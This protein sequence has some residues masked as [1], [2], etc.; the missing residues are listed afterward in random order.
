MTE[1]GSSA[2]DVLEQR[3]HL[4]KL[5][6]KQQQWLSRCIEVVRGG[7]ELDGLAL[8]VEGLDH[9]AFMEDSRAAPNGSVGD[10]EDPFAP[11]PSA[12]LI[13][14]RGLRELSSMLVSGHLDDD[15]IGAYLAIQQRMGLCSVGTQLVNPSATYATGHE[16]LPTLVRGILGHGQSFSRGFAILSAL[17]VSA[18]R[19]P[20][21]RESQ[22]AVLFAVP[23]TGGGASGK[24]RLSRLESGPSGIHPDPALMS[25]LIAD[26]E[27]LTS[28]ERAWEQSA[29]ADTDACVVWSVVR[30]DAPCN[31]INGGSMGAAFAVALDDLAPRHRIRGRLRRRK[32]DEDC[33]VTAGLDETRTN[34]TK[35]FGYREK[36]RVASERGLRVVV[37]ADA[38]DEAKEAAPDDFSDMAG[39]LQGAHTVQQAIAATRTEANP[40]YY[41]TLGAVVVALLSVV[42]GGAAMG[43]RI[44]SE[45]QAKVEAT[46]AKLATRSTELANQDSRLAALL[47]LASDMIDP[48]ASSKAAML[49]VI[50]NNDAIVGSV[51]A[52]T[53]PVHHVV[54]STDIAMSSGSGKEVA[55]WSLP[56]LERLDTLRLE[57]GASGMDSGP[58]DAFAILDGPGTIRLYQ[59]GSGRVPVE[60]KTIETGLTGG[61]QPVTGPIY[62][63]SGAVLAIDSTLRGVYWAPG[64]KDEMRFDL[65]GD[66]VL[67]GSEAPLNTVT[68]VSRWIE[69]NY[70]GSGSD[71]QGPSVLIGTSSNQIVR[72][73]VKPGPG[74]ADPP[75]LILDQVMAGRDVPADVLALEQD[76]DG[77]LYVGTG[78]GVLQLDPTPAGQRTFPFGGLVDRIES[79]RTLGGA[80][81]DILAITPAGM[82]VLNQTGNRA[83]NN[84]GSVDNLGTVTSFSSTYLQTFSDYIVVGRLDGRMMLVDPTNSRLTLPPL[85][86][87]IGAAFDP[88][89][90]LLT[91]SAYGGATTGNPGRIESVNR[92]SVGTPTGEGESAKDGGYARYE[93]P[94]Q[95]VYPFV[96]RTLSDGKL[97]VAVGS[98]PGGDGGTIWV[99]DANTSALTYELSFNAG[100]GAQ[101]VVL[102]GALIP[103]SKQLVAWNAQR[104]AVGIWSTETGEKVNEIDIPG[105]TGDFNV[106]SRS[107][108]T[109]SSDGST[110]LVQISA[111]GSETQSLYQVDTATGQIIATLEIPN[112]NVASLSPD[113]TK[114]LIGIENSAW[115]VDTAGKK[116]TE[117]TDLGAPARDAAW[118]PD[119]SRVAISL[120]NSD[121]V[122]MLD[123]STG[124]VSAPSWSSPRGEHPNTMEWSPTGEYLAV[125]TQVDDGQSIRPGP[126]ALLRTDA[127]DFMDS[128]CAIAGTDL[129]DEE[130]DTYVGSGVEKQPLCP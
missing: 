44:D 72:L 50:Q 108:M 40:L 55:V 42:G 70:Q 115:T 117:P 12:S 82:R 79:L 4:R 29:L 43:A 11:V 113:G 32:I 18:A 84:T 107:F 76:S 26:N 37:A 35:V 126:V 57:S 83:L 48:S 62:S 119:G 124:Q 93:L 78:G 122:V 6:G 73:V 61:R 22:I 116:L 128:L 56:G 14:A 106:V 19:P 3:N 110:V 88:Q 24:L 68:P 2:G 64:M 54:G 53:G 80:S 27:V 7:S 66:P 31:I 52:T 16:S 63:Q 86:P 15:T 121:R 41:V 45:R 38:F 91:T 90:R 101:D 21:K 75:T 87:S 39:R 125:T 5:I 112:L 33:A 34:L 114:I 17:E 65:S 25:F 77:M 36:L 30:D 28:I 103:A 118:S 71:S 95:G 98:T 49:N 123:G 51:A 105:A 67:D 9:K 23:G 94:L 10:P 92:R 47:A 99:W 127:I 46:A 100:G 59:G 20:T 96:H 89:G 69:R 8:D 60:V 13:T 74:R 111:V 97:M 102:N 85:L 81:N 120:N 104:G 1:V 130:W 109:S 58:N 129:S